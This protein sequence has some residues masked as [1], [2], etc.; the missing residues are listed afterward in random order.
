MMMRIVSSTMLVEWWWHRCEEQQEREKMIGERMP[1]L[2]GLAGEF[3]KKKIN[4]GPLGD[5]SSTLGSSIS[6]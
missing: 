5:H 6:P 4:R 2:E 1:T 3:L